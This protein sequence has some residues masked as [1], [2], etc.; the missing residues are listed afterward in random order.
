MGRRNELKILHTLAGGAFA[1]AAFS[2]SAG[3]CMAAGA[4]A[5]G[6][7]DD[8]AKQGLSLY[9]EVNSPTTKRAQQLALEG[10]KK[11]GSSTSKALCK[12]VA[13]FSNQC[14]AEAMDPKDGTPG[15]GWAIADTTDDA[16]KEAMAKCRATAGPDR[17]DACQVDD[18]SLWCDGSAK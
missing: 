17:Q 10:C 12:V 8:V 3:S 2:V 4:L 11:I 5:A 13:T 6:I 15:Y 7:P 18:R 16:R 14:A 9:T 1:L